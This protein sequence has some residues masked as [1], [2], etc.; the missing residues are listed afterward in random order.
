MQ[1]ASPP[2]NSAASNSATLAEQLTKASRRDLWDV[3]SYFTWP[4]ALPE[5]A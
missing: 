3:Y 1:P 4:D 5:D 2:S